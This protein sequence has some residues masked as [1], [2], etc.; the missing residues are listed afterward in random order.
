MRNH[1]LFNLY[2]E[3][4]LSRAGII[5]DTDSELK[6]RF[7]ILR[8]FTF[9]RMAQIVMLQKSFKMIPISWKMNIV[10]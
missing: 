3:S 4:L 5:F 6:V 9:S 10:I 8:L 2:F 7:P 1:K